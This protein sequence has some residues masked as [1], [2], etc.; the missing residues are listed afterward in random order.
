MTATEKLTR[1]TFVDQLIDAIRQDDPS[2]EFVFDSDRFRLFN[3]SMQINLGNLYED[4][5]AI[6][7]ELR[8]NHLVQL[9]AI[10][11]SKSLRKIPAEFEEARVHLRPKIFC[12]ATFEFM[13]LEQRREGKPEA[14]AI[15]LYPL[16]EHLYLSLAF[17]TETAI[18]SVAYEELQSW[19][20]NYWQA[21]EEARENL[22]RDPMSFS[23]L[24]D[25]VISAMAF[26]NYDSSRLVLVEQLEEVFKTQ[27]AGA[28]ICAVPHRDMMIAADESDLVGLEMFFS[29]LESSLET[30]VRPLSPLPLVWRDGEWSDWEP[31]F[32][33][34]LRSRWE[35]LRMEF[36]GGLYTQQKQLL[37]ALL[38]SGE[39][40]PFASS[41]SAI[42]REGVVTSY[43]IWG[44]GI[45][46]ALPKT[47]FIVFASERGIEAAASWEAVLE[48]CG[49]LMSR[50]NSYYPVRYRVER[51]PSETQLQRLGIQP[52]FSK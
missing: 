13:R 16:G 10:F 7:E 26:D 23:K 14:T 30:E 11:G 29:L 41:F 8:G 18:R 9:A 39:E 52:P 3:G 44:A 21:M 43:S 37:D 1:Q 40:L 51:F 6:P 19:G 31:E 12:R 47:D 22:R 34:P 35:R 4:H 36:L 38:D 48:E 49:S 32:E 17:D 45:D 24:G 28:P 50:D 20:V 46:A 33:H 25:S 2:A 15:P 42:E 27:W 5:C